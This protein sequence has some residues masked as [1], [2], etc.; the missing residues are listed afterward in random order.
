MLGPPPRAGEALAIMSPERETVLAPPLVSAAA[1]PPVLRVN[2]GTV[3]RLGTLVYVPRAPQQ[4][5]P[6]TGGEVLVGQ[7]FLLEVYELDQLQP[8]YR[9]EAPLDLFIPFTRELL[10]LV[11]GDP[12]ALTLKFYDE[13]VSPP[14]W[15]E[16]PTEIIGDGLYA[17]VD[18]LTVFSLTVEQSVLG[19]VDPAPDGGVIRT[20]SLHLSS[21]Y[22]RSLPLSVGDVVSVSIIVDAGGDAAGGFDVTL[23]YPTGLLEL[24]DVDF[25][26]SYCDEPAA[27]VH[28]AGSVK[29][30][31]Q[32]VGLGY[33]GAG[34]VLAELTMR[35]VGS[36]LATLSF[37]PGTRLL[38]A[39]DQEDILGF[40]PPLVMAID[41]AI[42]AV[43]LPEPI[44]VQLA[45]REG[46]SALAVVIA[47]FLVVLAAS[48]AGYA[49]RSPVRRA[50]LR[51]RLR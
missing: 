27:P 37:G 18:H 43:T 29:L 42:P 45:G 31:C 33:V 47:A 13:S 38:S 35:A 16:L 22:G 50:L 49:L 32:V 17:A 44:A 19:D 36:G 48:G 23:L 9:F 30:G 40:A 3:G 39:F 2:P 6:T 21:L 14:T 46:I 12:E 4:L 26:G 24:V 15:T 20:G 11:G 51:R 10:D 5:P 1:P 8:D 34:G 25:T 41:T 28:Q 7:P